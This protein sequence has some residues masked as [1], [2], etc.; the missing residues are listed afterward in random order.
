MDRALVRP[1]PDLVHGFGPDLGHNQGLAHAPLPERDHG[2]RDTP[3]V[4]QGDLHDL[5]RGRGAGVRKGLRGPHGRGPG[6][7]RAARLQAAT[8]QPRRLGDASCGAQVAPRFFSFALADAG[9]P[10][11]LDTTGIFFVRESGIRTS[12]ASPR[13]DCVRSWGAPSGRRLW[14]ASGRRSE[15]PSPSRRG[16]RLRCRAPRR[17]CSLP[18]AKATFCPGLRSS[19]AVR[20]TDRARLRAR[21]GGVSTA[22]TASTERTNRRDGAIIVPPFQDPE[23]NRFPQGL[24]PQGQPDVVPPPPERASMLWLD[25]ISLI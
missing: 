10:S 18:R 8:C 11:H 12:G 21:A 15:C 7:A 25:P 5:V 14:G 13:H 22:K 1:S 24:D 6:S 2:A 19:G 20:R 17:G 3:D 4:D 23:D 9:L 16:T